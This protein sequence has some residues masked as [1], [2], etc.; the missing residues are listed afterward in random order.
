MNHLAA[1]NPNLFLN[2][3]PQKTIPRNTGLMFDVVVV[4]LRTLRRDKPHQLDA[5]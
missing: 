1:L 3:N 2:L 5:K 4:R